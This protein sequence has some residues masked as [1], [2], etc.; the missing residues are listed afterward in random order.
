[1]NV[2]LAQIQAFERIARLGSFHAAARQLRLTQP[3]VSQRIRE[4]ED[5]LGVRLFLRRGPRI[6]LTADG[7]ALIPYAER[8]LTTTGEMIERFRTRDPLKGLLRLGLNESFGLVSL[9]RLLERLEERYPELQTSVQVG[10]TDKVSRLL[11]EQQLDIAVI[12]EPA[13]AEHVQRES[14]GVNELAWFVS[15]SFDVPE[16]TLSPADLCAHHLVITPPPARLYTT[17][18]QWF[19]QAGVVPRRLSMCNSLSVTI[20]SI[21]DGLAIG[22]VPVRT[23]QEHLASGAVRRLP[24]AP[25][26][27]GHRVWICHQGSDLGSGMKQ[28]VELVREVAAE[29]RLFV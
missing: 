11:N 3:S 23:M 2:T 8:I 18:T 26:V 21:V 12:S 14:L 7:T 28:I 22:L 25:P 10:D 9:T 15:S 6:S 29:D 16:S 19:A 17:A 27:P 20:L 5:S 13:V 4:L 24:V 1:M